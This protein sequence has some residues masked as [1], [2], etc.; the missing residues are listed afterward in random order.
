MLWWGMCHRHHGKFFFPLFFIV[1]WIVLWVGK[2]VIGLAASAIA[3]VGSSAF[4]IAGAGV[5]AFMMLIF[6]MVAGMI[7]FRAY[8][9]ATQHDLRKRKN[10][11]SSGSY[12][13]YFDADQDG[14]TYYVKDERGDFV[15]VKRV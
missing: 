10:G 5:I 6:G 11:A 3:L 13:D 4:L 9:T 1:P 7:L 12:A 14:R 8:H 2:A 15:P